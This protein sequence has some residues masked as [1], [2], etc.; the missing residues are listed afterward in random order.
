MTLKAQTYLR[1]W[2]HLKASVGYVGRQT[3]LRLCTVTLPVHPNTTLE[4]VFLIFHFY[5]RL[6]FFHLSEIKSNKFIGEKE[7]SP[8]SGNDHDLIKLNIWCLQTFAFVRT[9]RG[10]GGLVFP[11]RLLSATCLT[12][13]TYSLLNPPNDPARGPFCHSYSTQEVTRVWGGGW[14][15]PGLSTLI[16]YTEHSISV[17]TYQ[18]CFLF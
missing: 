5:A 15:T 3:C 4:P 10:G 18:C 16:L 14:L 7:G 12:E 2:C 8:P 13:L 9:P 6:N 11:D 1:P 17:N